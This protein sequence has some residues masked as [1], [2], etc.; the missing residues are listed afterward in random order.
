MLEKSILTYPEMREQIEKFTQDY[1]ITMMEQCKG[2]KKN[3]LSASV[4]CNGG[5]LTWDGPFENG[6]KAINAAFG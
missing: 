4:E 3:H 5:Q 1:N 6:M 2:L